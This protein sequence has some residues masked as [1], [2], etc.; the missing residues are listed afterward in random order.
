VSRRG[1][2]RPPAVAGS[3]YPASSAR[4][5]EQVDALLAAVSAT[6][7]TARLTAL[8]VPHAGYRY[9]G[10]VAASGYALLARLGHAVSRV[11]LLGPAHFVDLR[12]LAVPAASA[13]ATPL[14]EVPVDSVLRAAVRHL[15]GVAVDDRAH[16]TEH[17]FEVQLPFLQRV[18]PGATV[19]PVAV[20][21]PPEQV[22]DLVDAVLRVDPLTVTV[23]STD[24]SHYADQD[25]A[26]RRDRRT[27]D[28]VLAA[29]A[30]AVGDR[31]ACGAA[32]LRGLLAWAGR[33]GC[34][35]DELDLRT[36]GDVTG[37]LARVVGYG[38]FAVWE[39]RG[40]AQPD[41]SSKVS[42]T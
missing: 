27:A 14:G 35:I 15:P 1:G 25:S 21:A 31:D 20:A 22:V 36:S 7:R 34:D 10:P 23:V 8:V 28:A 19:L 33:D 12:G 32:A 29:D 40:P 39:A 11:L 3:F 41:Q 38:A 30:G 26:R 4:L 6:R 13:Y 16:A 17:A 2:V 37:D 18:V 9:S 42:P 24:L 5:K